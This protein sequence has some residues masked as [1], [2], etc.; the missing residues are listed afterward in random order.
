MHRVAKVPAY[1]VRR[2]TLRNQYRKREP[3]VQ[4]TIF[5]ADAT[6]AMQI[7]KKLWKLVTVERV[8]FYGTAEL[9]AK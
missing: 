8:P 2:L 6:E 9:E 3:E 5:A 4:R 1:R 7:A